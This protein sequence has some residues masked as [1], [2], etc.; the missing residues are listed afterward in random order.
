[1][2]RYLTPAKVGLLALIS[3]YSDSRV[4]I[5]ATIPILSFIV[6]HLLAL[7]RPDGEPVI[8]GVCAH[9][10]FLD[11]V[12]DFQK[13]TIT[14]A[15]AI[16]GRTIWDLLLKTLWEIN[17][18]DALDVF[19]QRSNASLVRTR[20][21][22]THDAE[23]DFE[24]PIEGQI[25]FSR[26]SPV[27]VFLRRAQLEFTR[28]QFHDTVSLWQA[29][30]RYREPT[31]HMWRKR[32]PR[33]GETSFDINIE[34]AGLDWGERLT[35]VV[36]G[37]LLNESSRLENT[38]STDDVERLLEFQVREMQSMF[39]CSSLYSHRVAETISR[40]GGPDTSKSPRAI[41][42]NDREQCHCPE[43]LPLCQIP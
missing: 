2:A 25:R 1:M 35:G 34:S 17:S 21:E 31:L 18:F 28:L 23:R 24:P 14:H 5:A 37:P 9:S 29:F 43:S 39:A 30:V 41:S 13:A 12:E 6:G 10:S 16:P 38:V 27:G 36:Y 32:N 11:A 33:A 8:E 20:E 42:Q 3:I 19:F 22:Q 26:T 4:P 15:S 7:G 40:N